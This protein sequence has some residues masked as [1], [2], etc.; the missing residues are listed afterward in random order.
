M[1]HPIKLV[2][3]ARSL[4]CHLDSR[5][6]MMAGK[7]NSIFDDVYLVNGLFRLLFPFVSSPVHSFFTPKGSYERYISIFEFAPLRVRPFFG[8]STGNFSSTAFSLYYTEKW[9]FFHENKHINNDNI[10]NKFIRVILWEN[11]VV[12]FVY[13]VTF[14]HFVLFMFMGAVYTGMFEIII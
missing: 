8:L 10:S 11:V 13:F 5:L 7:S 12:A 9:L 14:W 3:K 4:G 2:T 1:F 6:T